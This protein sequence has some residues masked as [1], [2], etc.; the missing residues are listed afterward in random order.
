L[1]VQAFEK[2]VVVWKPGLIINADDFG[3]HPSI[4]AGIL[5][6]YRNGVVSSLSL[7][8]T[9]PLLDEMCRELRASGAPAGLHLCLTQGRAISTPESLPDLVDETGNFRHNARKLLL[10]GTRNREVGPLLDQIG[11]EFSAQLSLARDYG[12]NLTHVDSH[13][14]IHMNPAIMSILEQLAP[15]FGACRIRW[16]YEPAWPLFMLRGI[17]QAVRRKNQL[18]WLFLRWLARATSAPSTATDSFL[19]V[20]HSG[21]MTKKVL[22]GLLRKIPATSSVEISIHPGFPPAFAQ[23]AAGNLSNPDRFTMSRFRQME[24]DALVDPETAEV[25]R[26][27]RL[28]L[29]SGAGVTKGEG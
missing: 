13:Q 4:N 19:G 26:R 25:I 9:M 17:H 3:V 15:K 12:V 14:H 7:M 22:I 8:V 21:I 20:I 10:L 16:T 11:N 27:R 23:G 29:T 18:K 1:D 5:S 28:R 2:G 6:A 24:H